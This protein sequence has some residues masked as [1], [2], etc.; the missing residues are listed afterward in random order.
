[1]IPYF[2]QPH[3][4]PIHAFGV[5]VATGILL[6]IRLIRKRS[7]LLGLDPVLA[8]KLSMR[9]VIVAFL[10]AHVFD[11]LAY[12]PAETLADPISLLK[13]WESISSFGGFIGAVIAGAWFVRSRRKQGDG[14]RYLDVITFN[15]P[16]GWFFGRLGCAMAY[17]HPGSPSTYFLSQVYRDGISRHNLGLE[18]ALYVLP[19]IVLFQILGRNRNRPTGFYLALF[20]L[21]YA[22]GRF[23]LDFMRHDDARYFGLT[24]GHYGSI[25]LVIVGIALM[26]W[27]HRPAKTA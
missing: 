16:I 14:W 22:P 8:E 15:F 4:G 10:C 7:T 3:L 11:R 26:R 9:I 2:P 19:I 25:A 24:P 18:E 13:I 17:D 27:V 21:V 12:Y 1:M 6:S 23:I 20:P 5:L